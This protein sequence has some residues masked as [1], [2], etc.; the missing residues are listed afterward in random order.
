MPWAMVWRIIRA[1]TD[2]TA[3]IVNQ[4]FTK[5]QVQHRWSWEV[6]GQKRCGFYRLLTP[7]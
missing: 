5:S 4:Q 1:F 6:L 2:A 3:G 7:A